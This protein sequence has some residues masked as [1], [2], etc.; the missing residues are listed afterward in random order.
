[1]GISEK[2]AYIKGLFDG[3]E[4]D[5]TKKEGKILSELLE[6]VSDM[7]DKIN[8]L[9]ED[10]AELHEYVEEIDKDNFATEVAQAYG[11]ALKGG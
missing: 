4:L 6:L 3:Y 10:N 5:A 7:A 8:A 1:M 2:A 9:E 11:V